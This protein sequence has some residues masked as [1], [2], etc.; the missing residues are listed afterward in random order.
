MSSLAASPAFESRP[1]HHLLPS[2]L[3]GVCVSQWR[4]DGTSPAQLVLN[5]WEPGWQA[6][7]F[8]YVGVFNAAG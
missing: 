7:G 2:F 8:F 5:Y 6:N 4:T 3:F 1:L